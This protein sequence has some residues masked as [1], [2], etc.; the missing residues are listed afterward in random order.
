MV[1]A[2][3]R[4]L[5]LLLAG[6]AVLHA[7]S[8]RVPEVAESALRNGVKVLSVE[9]PGCPAVRVRLFLKGGRADTGRLPPVAS[10]LLARTL[11]GRFTAARERDRIEAI[12]GQEQGAFE[13][14]RLERL[15]M[16]R[17]PKGEASPEFESLR[18][19]HERFMNELSKAFAPESAWDALDDLGATSRRV[20]VTA[21][22]VAFG[23]DLPLSGLESWCRLIGCA[24]CPWRPSPWNGTSWN[25]I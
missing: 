22:Y 11:F 21:D 7:Q 14:L 19:L 18:D 8:D 20:D 16:A 24:P 23:L 3:I 25:R 9:R 12:L 2:A 4:L 10:D 15:R 17:S 1:R 13:A 5:G 6:V